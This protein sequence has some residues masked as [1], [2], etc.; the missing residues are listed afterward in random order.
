MSEV[1]I[2][3]RQGEA[4][5]TYSKN[6]LKDYI[7]DGWQHIYTIRGKNMSLT[8]EVEEQENE[9]LIQ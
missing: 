3:T 2:L 5:H 8:L 1:F 9:Q 4:V 7:N 6:Y